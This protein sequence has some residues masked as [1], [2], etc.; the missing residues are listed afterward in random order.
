MSP[1]FGA[2]FLW[3]TATILWWS[4]WREEG[5]AGL[6]HRAV[7][8]FLAVWPFA[9]LANVK[10]TPTVSINGAWVWTFIAIILLAWRMPSTRRWMS[11]SAGFLIGSIYVLLSRIAYYPS[12]FSHFF[13]SWGTAVVVGWLSALLLRNVSEQVL[14]V[15][16]GLYLS[17]GL[18]VY[19]H[20]SSIDFPIVNTSEW[21]EGWWIA[22]LYARLWSASVRVLMESTR[23]LTFKLGG[24]R[25]GQRP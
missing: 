14:A 22:V 4:G 24:K 2:V 15:S 7:G 9:W 6:S 21:V 3:L 23:R 17:E 13:A 1:A 11:V 18:A 16:A 5:S 12:G 10:F 8:V 20:A 19:V 25:G